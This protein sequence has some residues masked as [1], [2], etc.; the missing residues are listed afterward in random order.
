MERHLYKEGNF[1]KA[2]TPA[3]HFFFFNPVRSLISEFIQSVSQS[4]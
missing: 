1:F 4:T 3:V 2:K